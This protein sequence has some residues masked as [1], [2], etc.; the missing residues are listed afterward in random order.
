[1][2]PRLQPRVPRAPMLHGGPRGPRQPR[3]L[4]TLHSTDYYCSSFWVP[5]FGLRRAAWVTHAPRGRLLSG[6]RVCRGVH[7]CGATVRRGG[8]GS[9]ASARGKRGGGGGRGGGGAGAPPHSNRGGGGARVPHRETTL[10]REAAGGH[11]PCRRSRARARTA[12]TQAP[13]DSGDAGPV[14][15]RTHARPG[16]NQ[17]LGRAGRRT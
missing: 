6:T 7:T 9:A 10:R 1:M 13:A 4:L 12:W 2:S 17:R 15:A 8:G 3:L 16:R 14:N 11:G 5:L